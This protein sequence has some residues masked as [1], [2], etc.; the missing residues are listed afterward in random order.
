MQNSVSVLSDV[1]RKLKHPHEDSWDR[2]CKF[3]LLHPTVLIHNVLLTV[4][5]LPATL[6]LF[7]LSFLLHLHGHDMQHPGPYLAYTLA[8]LAYTLA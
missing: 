6:P 4:V 2:I 3:F 7:R 8:Y 1:P 5:I